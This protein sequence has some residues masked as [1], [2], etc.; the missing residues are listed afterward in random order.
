MRN[1]TDEGFTASYIDY[2]WKMK[3][4]QLKIIRTRKYIFKMFFLVILLIHE[5]K[6]TFQLFYFLDNHPLNSLN[7]CFGIHVQKFFTSHSSAQQF[8]R[9]F[10]KRF[11]IRFWGHPLH[12]NLCKMTMLTLDT[13]FHTFLTRSILMMMLRRA[14]RIKECYWGLVWIVDGGQGR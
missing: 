14:W 6:I 3:I 7:I 1:F 12:L 9:M 13:L 8:H 10:K 11:E 4:I 2:Q 5:K